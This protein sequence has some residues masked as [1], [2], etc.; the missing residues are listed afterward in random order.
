MIYN[1]YKY[2]TDNLSSITFYCNGWQE[3]GEDEAVNIKEA[4]NDDRDWFDRQDTTIVI[5]SRSHNR[6]N[7]RVNA[8][9]VYNLI[10][11]KYGLTLPAITV[12]GTVY[13]E[14]K[15]W[16]IRPNSGPQY[17]GDDESGRPLFSFSLE[18]T[19][20]YQTASI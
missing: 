16:A 13:P 8:L 7:A 3:P 5:L 4:S 11:K 2:L 18:V 9:T 6:I 19:T 1:L 15:T 14:I 10:K 20:T 17:A 12:S